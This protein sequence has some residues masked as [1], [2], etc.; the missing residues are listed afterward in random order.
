MIKEGTTLAE[1][2]ARDK[3]LDV[4]SACKIIKQVL[5]VLAYMH[6]RGVILQNLN[7]EN[8][9]V[10]GNGG[11]KIAD[12][13]SVYYFEAGAVSP[14]CAPVAVEYMSP[15]KFYGD[16]STESDVFSAGVLFYR[17]LTGHFPYAASEIIS[18]PDDAAKPPPLSRYNKSIPPALEN[19]IMKAVALKKKDRFPTAK[20]FISALFKTGAV[21]RGRRLWKGTGISPVPFLLF[22][23]FFS[24]TVSADDFMKASKEFVRGNFAEAEKNIGEYLGKKPEDKKAQ[25]LYQEICIKLSKKSLDGGDE[26]AARSYAEKAYK[27]NPNNAKARDLYLATKKVEKVKVTTE[28]I[29]SE[30]VK[31]RK[32]KLESPEF[33]ETGERSQEVKTKIEYE[34][35][36]EY[37]TKEMIQQVAEIPDWIWVSIAFNAVLMV[38]VYLIYKYKK[39][40]NKTIYE[41]YLRTKMR[42]T[43]YLKNDPAAV[44]KQ[45][46]DERAAEM[47]KLLSTQKV[48]D[49]VNIKFVDANRAF[50]DINPIPRLT[51]DM[52]ELSEYFLTDP[53][54]IVN[55]LTP[56]LQHKNNRARA[57]AAKAIYKYKPV[58]AMKTIK[59]MAESEDRW[60]K[61]SAVWACS[62]V[63]DGEAT[64]I[65]ERLVADND[66][67]VSLAATQAR[68]DKKVAN[69]FKKKNDGKRTA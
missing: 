24:A 38:G 42:L 19:V 63:N 67:E 39:K 32:Q 48:P 5:E 44:K 7:P 51:A 37:I 56:Y 11:I 64:A 25:N 23:L 14:A 46:G 58:L 26:E 57:N 27:V 52:V 61:I 21:K 34:T 17:M 50:T 43:N 2:M 12:L 6:S 36:T 54:E 16:V 31:V 59:K 3:W 60:E 40:G 66:M 4:K 29:E 41:Q 47:F 15:Q 45:L 68:N 22:F 69:V 8:I 30:K 13:G 35:R 20:S 53:K 18:Y 33:S 49:T 1:L 55:F 62:Q 9:I 28:K 65:L 10:S